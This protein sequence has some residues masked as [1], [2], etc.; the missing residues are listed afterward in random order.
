MTDVRTVANPNRV[1]NL[2]HED[3]QEEA[4]TST[5]ESSGNEHAA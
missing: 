3:F 1:R 4:S 2:S 5:S